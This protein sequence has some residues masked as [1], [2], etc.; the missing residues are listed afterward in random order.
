MEPRW[1]YGETMH[2]ADSDDEPAAKA[3]RPELVSG[4][5]RPVLKLKPNPQAAA[6][7][8]AKAKS[9]GAP[10]AGSSSSADAAGSSIATSSKAPAPA[11]TAKSR[12]QSKGATPRPPI[13][14]LKDAEEA[15]R[16]RRE[17]RE[18]D[19]RSSHCRQGPQLSL[20]QRTG[21]RSAPYD[22]SGSAAPALPSSSNRE[23]DQDRRERL[24]RSA[25]EL[26]QRGT[27]RTVPQRWT[28]E[29]WDQWRREHGEGRQ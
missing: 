22:P 12:P 17:Y 15:A 13:F 26:V 23:E 20:A 4:S 6:E 24:P 21:L 25:S 14:R 3:A 7:D 19:E 18:S 2:A 29:E 28:D 8:A 1:R 11:T 5:A 9:A 27:R 16:E 10:A